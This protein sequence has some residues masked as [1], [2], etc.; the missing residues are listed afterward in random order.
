MKRIV[1]LMLFLALS[2]AAY[3]QDRHEVVV[4]DFMSSDQDATT[5][6]ACAVVFRSNLAS[7]LQW[8]LVDA[9]RVSNEMVRMNYDKATVTDAQIAEICDGLGIDDVITGRLSIVDGM[10]VLEVRVLNVPSRK[11]KGEKSTSWK[12]GTPFRNPVV[13]LAN[14]I[15][16]LITLS[17]NDGMTS[18]AANTAA[19][20]GTA[21]NAG[22]VAST[23]VQ[24][25]QTESVQVKQSVQEEKPAPAK[26]LPSGLL[27]NG[28]D[29]CAKLDLD[30]EGGEWTVKVTLATGSIK[31][32]CVLSPPTSWYSATLSESG[33]LKLKYTLNQG[34]MRKGQVVVMA[35][36]ERA[37]FSFIQPALPNH[38]EENVW[39][40]KLSRLLGSP[41][42]TYT[43]GA[44]R[45]GI[46]DFP[47]PDTRNGVG[48]YR[49]SDDT[50]Y[51]GMW[52]QNRK[53]GKGIH[54]TPK[55]LVFAQLPGCRIMVA[56]FLN[57][58]PRGNMR[59]YDRHGKLL[60]DGPVFDWTPEQVY[61]AKELNSNHRFDFIQYPDGSCYIGEVSGGKKDGY[62]LFIDSTGS[63]WVGTWKADGK[64][65]GNFF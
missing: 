33:D 32:D 1:F 53:N 50:I 7:N 39:M 41:T 27:V 35:G 46:V 55:G 26:V 13:T 12:R 3:A 30:P 47:A 4:M 44:Y 52:S 14:D 17:V 31:E 28:Y 36:E 2:C 58:V 11:V 23:P 38:I 49:W 37:V 56:D 34:E 10:Y 62:G 16:P 43:N 63:P 64:V 8:A 61:P 5:S 6:E 20:G 54:S 9:F 29:S 45:G 65:N 57:D 25:T 40:S 59:C 19:S 48:L 15:K 22:V 60:Y 18:L 42:A 21:G 24:Q 51:L